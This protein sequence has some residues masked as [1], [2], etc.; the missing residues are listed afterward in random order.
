MEV[1]K[2]DLGCPTYPK[3]SHGVKMECCYRVSGSFQYALLSPPLCFLSL[4]SFFLSTIPVLSPAW[5]VNL[6]IYILLYCLGI[7]LS[8]LDQEVENKGC[9]STL[10]LS[11]VLQLLFLGRDFK[12][13][14]SLLTLWGSGRLNQLFDM[15]ILCWHNS[16]EP[17]NGTNY[18]TC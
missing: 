9:T 13:R 1:E 17:Y 18:D 7:K 4:C 14:C 11:C 15:H 12:T 5:V 6:S 16:P 10:G 8:A 3:Q 2:V